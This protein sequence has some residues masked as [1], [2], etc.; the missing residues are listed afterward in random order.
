[1][2]NN[3]LVTILTGLQIV[4][5]LFFVML[6][7][8]GNF[9]ALRSLALSPLLALIPLIIISVWKLFLR[10]RPEMIRVPRIRLR[11]ERRT[12]LALSII[13]GFAFLLRLPYLSYHYGLLNSDAAIFCLEGKH[14][15][16]GKVPPVCSYGQLYHGTLPGHFF[17]LVFKLFGYST[18]AFKLS[19]FILYIS[20][21]IFH[22]FFLQKFFPFTFALIASLFYFLPLGYLVPVSMDGDFIFPLFFLFGLVIIF[23]AV[24]IAEKRKEK[25]IFWVGFLAGLTFWA[26]PLSVFFT[27]VAIFLIFLAYKFK[28]KIYLKL[29]FSF[30]IGFFPQLLLEINYGFFLARFLSGK[31]SFN[32]EKIKKTADL[33]ATLITFSHDPRRLFLVYFLLLGFIALIIYS[34]KT[35]Q[36]MIIKIYISYVIFFFVLYFSSVHSDVYFVRYLYPLLF[37]TPL[38]FLSIFLFIKG[39]AK[40]LIMA[41]FIIF[42]FVFF[43]LSPQYN[44][45]QAVKEAHLNLK[46]IASFLEQSGQRYWR[47]DF[48]TSYLLTA[49]TGERVVI[50]STSLRRYYSYELEYFNNYNGKENFIFLRGEGSEERR[51][52]RTLLKYLE[53]LGVKYEKKEIGDCWLIYNIEGDVPKIIEPPASIPRISSPE[54]EIKNGFLRLHFKN[55]SPGDKDVAFSLNAEIPAFSQTKASFS[56]KDE[57]IACE[58]AFPPQPQFKIIYYLDYWGTKIPNTY[59]EVDFTLPGAEVKAAQRPLL[60]YLYGLGAQVNYENKNLFVCMKEVR[61]EVNGKPLPEKTLSLVLYSPFKFSQLYWYGYYFQEVDVLLNGKLLFRRR[62]NEGKN[63]LALTYKDGPWNERNN[64]ITLRFKYHFRFGFTPRWNTAALLEKIEIN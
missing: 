11:I 63:V 58:I 48:W 34:L 41:G 33:I 22:F 29:F 15:A 24:Q 59:G 2:R 8:K 50:A 35:K 14:I 36:L 31:P 51:S 43:D 37:V 27:A 57:D 12:L 64:V 9:P 18:L 1:M 16:E 13:L 47:G 10:S 61:V 4:L 52:A 17:A 32:L 7:F 5:Y 20:F 30:L 38:L 3:K 62:L 53:A 45:F 25:Y 55:L 23:L 39:K 60:V 42:V 54:I 49:I 40:Y 46:K 56:L 26:N 28:L 6:W 44:Y 21:I 19:T